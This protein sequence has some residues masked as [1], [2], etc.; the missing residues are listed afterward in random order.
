MTSKEKTPLQLFIAALRQSL[1]QDTRIQGKVTVRERDY[2]A[3]I[4]CETADAGIVTICGSQFMGH[5]RIANA[6]VPSQIRLTNGNVN[7]APIQSF[8]CGNGE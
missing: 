8:A 7:F 3:L 6:F 1:R 5:Q 2:Q 4:T